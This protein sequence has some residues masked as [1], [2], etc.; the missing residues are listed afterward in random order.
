ME[1]MSIA[2]SVLLTVLAYSFM[3]GLSLVLFSP[4]AENDKSA[5]RMALL[6]PIT[7]PGFAGVAIATIIIDGVRKWRNRRDRV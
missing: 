4:V 7:L 5:V 3:T 1:E 6:W 2:A